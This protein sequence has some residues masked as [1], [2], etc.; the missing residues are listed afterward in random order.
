MLSN[1][2]ST[3]Q[4]LR[5]F[6]LIGIRLED[7]LRWVLRLGSWST[8]YPEGGSNWISKGCKGGFGSDG[9]FSISGNQSENL[10]KDVGSSRIFTKYWG[11]RSFERDPHVLVGLLGS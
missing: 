9:L 4:V 3:K 10:R 11:S 5:A 8:E 2:L 6:R 1:G 7:G